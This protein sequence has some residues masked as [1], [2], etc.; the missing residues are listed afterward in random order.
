MMHKKSLLITLAMLV[1][2]FNIIPSM[3]QVLAPV[4][5]YKYL[6]C[7]TAP[8]FSDNPPYEVGQK[9]TFWM[10]YDVFANENLDNIVVYDRFGGELMIDGIAVNW[11]TASTEDVNYEFAY[12]PYAY[13][14]EVNINGGDPEGYLDKTGVEIVDSI[15]GYGFKIFWTGKS[16]KAHFQWNVG[17]L[18]AGEF[19]RLWVVVSTDNNPAGK[20]EYTSCGTYTLN[21]GA[22]VKARLATTGKQVSAVSDAIQIEVI[23]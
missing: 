6:Y 19:K 14:G 15:E 8:G 4:E 16:V 10:V 20:P 12:N 1:L 7:D 21:S 18:N 5:V 11:A 22:T 9:Y 3:A 2:A 13:G 17:S 23:P